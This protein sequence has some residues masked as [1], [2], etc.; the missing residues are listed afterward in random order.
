MRS[1][2]GVQ[3]DEEK[4]ASVLPNITELANVDRMPFQNVIVMEIAVVVLEIVLKKVDRMPFQNVI[5]MKIVVAVL[6]IVL[7]KV[8][9]L[10][11]ETLDAKTV[12]LIG[13]NRKEE[14]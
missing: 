4:T 14:I 13:V 2:L 11:L 7:K 8:V 10:S 5:V 6:E 1:H 12:N 9:A 3:I